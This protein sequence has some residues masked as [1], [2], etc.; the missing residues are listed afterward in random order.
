MKKGKD[1]EKICDL[2]DPV[3]PKVHI[4]SEETSFLPFFT[5]MFR[6]CA[7]GFPETGLLGRAD[8]VSVSL[9]QMPAALRRRI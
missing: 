9:A 5:D 7:G 6:V 3:L 2:Y 1:N 4:R 8:P